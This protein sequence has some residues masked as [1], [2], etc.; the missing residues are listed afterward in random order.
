MGGIGCGIGGVGVAGAACVVVVAAAADIPSGT[1]E[2]EA[3]DADLSVFDLVLNNT[4]SRGLALLNNNT[5]DDNDD[6][7][8]HDEDTRCAFRVCCPPMEKVD[9]V[10]ARRCRLE[11]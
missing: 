9:A 7:Q 5:N 6:L 11:Q 10:A 3:D 2:N 4:W 1:V 8:K